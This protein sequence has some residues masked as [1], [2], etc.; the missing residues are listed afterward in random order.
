MENVEN[1]FLY[2][3]L[4]LYGDMFKITANSV[5]SSLGVIAD[6]EGWDEVIEFLDSVE[7]TRFVLYPIKGTPE[8][9]ALSLIFKLK[10]D[11]EFPLIRHD[12][13][14]Y[15]DSNFN[16]IYGGDDEFRIDTKKGAG[17]HI[18]ESI[19]TY[20]DRSTVAFDFED[21]YRFAKSQFEHT[22]GVKV[23]FCEDYFSVRFEY[24]QFDITFVSLGSCG[25]SV[26]ISE[27]PGLNFGLTEEIEI[28]RYYRG[29]IYAKI[30][31]D[32]ESEGD[33]FSWIK[34]ARYLSELLLE[35]YMNSN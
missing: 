11:E 35:N 26:R 23:D 1:K 20:L 24:Y 4:K 32:K 7:V 6:N 33:E 34:T 5:I 25:I 31:I 17:L 10:N 9:L 21:F 22:Q 8:E 27:L 13:G 28:S 14:C 15:M 19:A 2:M 18:L 3:F 12:W 29:R 30:I 16:V